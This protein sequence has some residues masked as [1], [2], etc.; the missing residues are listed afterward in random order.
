MSAY[1][2]EHMYSTRSLSAG[3]GMNMINNY[4]HLY[5]RFCSLTIHRF[6]S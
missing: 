1:G 3:S 2:H 4:Y 6:S 5:G